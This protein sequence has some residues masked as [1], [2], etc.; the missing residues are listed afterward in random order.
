MNQIHNAQEEDM[1]LCESN[2]S[3]TNFFQP[4]TSLRNSRSTKNLKPPNR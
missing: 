3:R 2:Q 4:C 1:A